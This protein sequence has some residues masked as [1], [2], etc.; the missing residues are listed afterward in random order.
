MGNSNYIKHRKLTFDP[1]K[2]FKGISSRKS[3]KMKYLSNK[4]NNNIIL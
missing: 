4:D 2:R 3:H 1:S